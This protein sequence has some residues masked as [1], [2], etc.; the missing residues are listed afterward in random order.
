MTGWGRRWS[1]G[2]MPSTTTTPTAA[3]PAVAWYNRPVPA[4]AAGVG[5]LALC[6]VF[7][8]LWVTTPFFLARALGY[9]SGGAGLLLV[10]GGF[11]GL[12]Q[13]RA[14]QEWRA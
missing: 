14:E 6:G 4:L 5:L 3:A 2:H 13:E 9:L 8:V 1:P 12:R 11:N 10:W 7:A